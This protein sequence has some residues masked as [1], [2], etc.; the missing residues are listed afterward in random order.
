MEN[1]SRKT[2]TLKPSKERFCAEFE[3]IGQSPVPD[4]AKKL[5]DSVTEKNKERHSQ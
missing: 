1:N 5:L 3:I 4:S 2:K